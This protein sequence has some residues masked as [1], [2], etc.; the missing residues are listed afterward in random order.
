MVI[1][2]SK[3]WRKVSL[4]SLIETVPCCAQFVAL[5]ADQKERKSLLPFTNFCP[6][7]ERTGVIGDWFAQVMAFTPFEKQ[8]G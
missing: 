2:R 7:P 3:R 8:V 4:S 5:M 1:F 6:N